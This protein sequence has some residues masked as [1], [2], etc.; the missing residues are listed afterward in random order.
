MLKLYRAERSDTL[1]SALATL[2]RTP[3]SDP[4]ARETVAV[5]AKGVE[6]WLNQRLSSQLGTSGPSVVDGISANIAFPSPARLVAESVAA[7][8]GIT[9]DDDPWSPTRLVWTVLDVIDES[10]GE[11]WC[12]V[13]AKHLEGHREGR[14]FASATHVTE[15]FRSYAA[16][17]PQMLIDWAAGRLTDGHGLALS[18]DFEWQA[19][20]WCI[21]A[22]K[23]DVPGPAERLGQVSRALVEDPALV[24]L[25]E[26]LSVFGPTRLPVDQR[27]ILS[28]LSANRDVHI[29]LPHPS[30][31]LWTKM[32]SRI[33]PRSESTIRR[34]EDG[35][36][37]ISANPLLS[38]LARDVRELQISLGAAKFESVHL[39]EPAGPKSLLATVKADVIA[40]RAPSVAAEPDGT[41][42]VHA[43]HG[44]ARQ[45]EVLRE[46]LLRLFEDD[47]TLQP[48]DVLVMCPDV[49]T[50]APLVRAAFGQ[51][52]HGHP[53]H[54]LRVRLAD[55]GLR[56][57]NPVLAVLGSLLELA[58][59]RATAS[60]VL[61]LAATEPVRTRF[62]WGDDELERLREWTTEAGARWGIGSRQ[63]ATFGLDAFPQNTFNTAMDRILLGVS[64][65]ESENAWLDLALPLDDVDGTDIDLTGRFAEFVDRL[66]VSLRDLAGPHSPAEWLR[67]LM[68][69]LDLLT[70]TAPA[71]SWQSA[72]AHRELVA[73]VEFGGE[74]VLRLA[75]V[76][77]MLS[78]SLAGRPTRA[79][80]RTGELTVCT[81]VPMRSVPHRVVVL[82]G[83][84]DEVFPRTGGVDGDDILSRHPVVGER[85]LR[86]EDRQLLLDAVM[87]AGE[88]LILLYTGADPVTGVVRP[89]AIPL[90][91]LLD[92]LSATVGPDAVNGVLTRHPL[93]S[94]DNRNFAPNKPF[95]FD[96]AALAG[97][98][99]AA[100]TPI[101]LP[102]VLSAKLLEVHP[103]EVNLA[104]LVNFLVHPARGF[105]RQRLGVRVPELDD[106][107]ADSLATELDPLSTWAL[108]DR[109]LLSRLAGRSSA[110]FRAA[111]WRRGTLPPYNL[112]ASVLGNVEW[113]V[114]Q[115]AG[116]A[117]PHLEGDS[118]AVDVDIDLGDGRRLT[119]TVTGV[120]GNSV[121]RASYSSL[122]PKHRMTA[123]INLL[124]LKAH[125]RPGA[126]DA[127]SIGRG[128][129][130]IAAARSVLDAPG[131]AVEIL[132]QLVNL[133]ER[134]L[135]RPLPMWAATSA[136]YARRRFGGESVDDAT[137]G[138]DTQWTGQYGEMIDPS[139][140][141]VFGEARTLAELAADPPSDDEFVWAEE[142]TRFGVLA[143]RLWDPLL[144]NERAE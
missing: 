4:F 129:G 112:G 42:Q 45:V 62:S 109:M 101:E 82:I 128:R 107:I 2:L 113:V 47:P 139:N 73:A 123:W 124:A 102:T 37:L 94:F 105:L 7:V 87:S 86:S 15:L 34:S 43:C 40:D 11:P 59:G 85:D 53:G 77:A 64:A 10:L 29:W 96:T 27:M 136:E 143:R 12:G 95:S 41:V 3:L 111:E 119:G 31:A 25:P 22:D 56:Q 26:R 133:R 54:L 14:R 122:A 79:N 106:D 1:V 35:S 74:T 91:G 36:A 115:L 137:N 98:R 8:S 5:P 33:P 50:Y 38:S 39:P 89:P 116:L 138:A 9:A 20:L 90:S 24:D 23:I 16:Q 55:R 114:D 97:A 68:R 28:A 100:G 132:Q 32:S 130:K 120:H 110:D 92:V 135:Q 75:D 72:G 48:R 127:V 134:G 83:L 58:D 65:D 125:G 13:L 44:P 93:Q 131:N 126:L 117:L 63:R 6:R 17:R 144:T 108:G 49:E 67:V 30:P 60:E 71:D 140:A 103:K 69:A 61:D 99:A 78:R 141:Y 142:P 76:R 104:D 121:V 18:E 88:H 66:A 84:D 52:V 118:E 46:C 19:R 80:F 21:V 51:G 81:M 70:D 57:T